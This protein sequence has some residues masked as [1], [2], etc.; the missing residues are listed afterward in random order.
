MNV[1]LALI[2]IAQADLSAA[3]PLLKKLSVDSA[4]NK[5]GSALRTQVWDDALL[6]EV[7]ST[8]PEFRELGRIFS[9]RASTGALELKDSLL[10]EWLKRQAN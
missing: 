6:S 9:K 4:D 2:R 3:E 7:C 1:L 5:P 8:R 10:R